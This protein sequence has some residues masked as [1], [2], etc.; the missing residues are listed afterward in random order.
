MAANL[1]RIHKIP[2][3][4]V[5]YVLEN[6]SMSK[7]STIALVVAA[8]SGSRFGIKTPKQYA[9]LG[10]KPLLLHCLEKL[11]K[12]PKI[13]A[14]AV[15]IGVEHREFY[16]AATCNLQPE[17]LL[18]PIHGGK[19]R[20]DS[21]RLGLKAIAQYNPKRVLIHDAAR[22]NLSLSLLDR[23]L[24][25]DEDAVIPA[26]PMVDTVKRVT[27]SPSRLEGEGRGGGY[28]AATLEKAKTLHKNMTEAEKTLWKYISRKQ[29][30][31]KFRRQQPIGNYI[32]DFYNTDHGLIIEIDGGQHA[33]N[34]AADEK[35]T[36]YLEQ[37]GYRVLRFWNNEVLENI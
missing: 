10:G 31:T 17:T 28:S 16:E 26:L 22:P 9:L 25:S 29:S 23:L 35:R 24:E 20:Q 32:V 12:H 13:D 36:K 30:G 7:F 11:L 33:I 15:V 34:Q 21:V 1:D 6:W 5:A 2:L 18:P 3:E 27:T 19:E 14:V 4:I 8:G 37:S